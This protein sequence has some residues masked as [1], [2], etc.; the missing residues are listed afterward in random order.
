MEAWHLKSTPDDLL[1]YPVAALNVTTKRWRL[2][3]FPANLVGIK[4]SW[5]RGN[6]TKDWPND[7][8]VYP[9][10]GSLCEWTQPCENFSCASTIEGIGATKVG[11]AHSNIVGLT[12]GLIVLFILLITTYLV[13]GC[14][15]SVPS[16]PSS[17]NA[18]RHN[19][20]DDRPRP[21]EEAIGLESRLPRQ[22]LRHPRPSALKND[23]SINKYYKTPERQ[24][25]QRPVEISWELAAKPYR[26][27]GSSSR[28]GQRHWAEET[29]QKGRQI[30]RCMA[31]LR[32][33]YALDLQ[34]WSMEDVALRE[35]DREVRVRLWGRVERIFLE[36]A[37]VVS[38]WRNEGTR[39]V[40]GLSYWSDE[41]KRV[42]DAIYQTVQEHLEGR[43]LGGPEET[44]E[45]GVSNFWSKD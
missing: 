1:A 30:E 13:M 5:D 31:L 9:C 43:R 16:R 38:S 37:D 26:R 24:P 2:Q 29:R 32:E 23:S 17:R 34:A 35:G 27:S 36:V 11:P 22:P 20:E 14:H 45:D 21:A 19:T 10:G 7:T 25:T 39:E 33:M 3:P 4:G 41:E 15:H 42:I 40:P 8:I 28:D 44:E 12:H 18:H 6:A